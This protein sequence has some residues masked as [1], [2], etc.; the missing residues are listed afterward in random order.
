MHCLLPYR[1]T[2]GCIYAWLYSCILLFALIA[3]HDPLFEKNRHLRNLPNS[4]NVDWT[5]QCVFCP[6][7]KKLQA[8]HFSL[9]ANL[10]SF[11]VRWVGS[12][13]AQMLIKLADF[14]WVFHF[15][16]KQICGPHRSRTA[17]QNTTLTGNIVEQIFIYIIIR[18]TLCFVLLS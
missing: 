11:F 13:S 9:R 15:H 10:S 18:Q 8:I 7:W 6:L 16:R 4:M 1:K 2:F 14:K 3:V 5:I 17:W 12:G